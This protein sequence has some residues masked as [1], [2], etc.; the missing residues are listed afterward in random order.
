MFD[1][2]SSNLRSDHSR[3]WSSGPIWTTHWLLDKLPLV[4]TNSPL[5]SPSPSL[6][7]EMKRSVGASLIPDSLQTVPVDD[8]TSSWTNHSDECESLL[9]AIFANPDGNSL[10]ID[11]F[12]P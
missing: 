9:D 5:R 4:G 3:G 10:D 2:S 11:F 6:L 8:I 7:R 1:A 12:E